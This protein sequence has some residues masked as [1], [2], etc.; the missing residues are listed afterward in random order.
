MNTDKLTLKF[1]WRG[2][3]HRIANLILKEE[4]KVRGLKQSD[5]KTY[6]ENTVTNTVWDCGKNR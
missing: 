4:N 3:R 6:Y 2:K 5:F 1:I